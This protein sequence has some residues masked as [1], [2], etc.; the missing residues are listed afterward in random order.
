MMRFKSLAQGLAC[1]G[2]V[3]TAL[4]VWPQGAHAT[5]AGPSEATTADAQP[6]PVQAPGV[7]AHVATLL[8]ELR[9]Y[10][11]VP[12]RFGGASPT[13]GFDCSGLIQFAFARSL[14][15]LLPRTPDAQASR[16]EPVS[17]EALA[18]GDLV[19]F[20][21]RGRTYSHVGVYVGDSKFIHAPH[22]GARVRIDDLRE[23]YYTRHF[24]D[25]RRLDPTNLQ[26]GPAPWATTLPRHAAAPMYTAKRMR[27]V[28]QK[29]RPTAAAPA[30][31][32]KKARGRR[33]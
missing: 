12:Y 8:A 23:A 20:N 19:F 18:P 13:S 5:P 25:A 9:A 2:L 1:V 33:T 7:T 10:L 17:R 6:H 4:S 11:G 30:K 14:G 26:P 32:T 29:A 31:R 28:A 16:G 22:T 3:L 27:A 15:V 21:T 24:T